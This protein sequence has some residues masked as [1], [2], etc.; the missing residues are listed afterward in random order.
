MATYQVPLEDMQFILKEVAE[1][2]KVLSLPCFSDVN[3][4]LIDTILIE[5]GKFGSDVL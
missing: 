1:L 2:D 3:G 5:A 4:K